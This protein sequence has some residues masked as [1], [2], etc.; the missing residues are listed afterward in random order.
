[1]EKEDGSVAPEE[2][3][4]PEQPVKEVKPEEEKKEEKKEEEKK[5]EKEEEKEEEEEEEEKEEEKEKIE[6]SDQVVNEVMEPIEAKAK[7]S[8]FY[9][10]PIQPS[11]HCLRWEVNKAVMWV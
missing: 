2:S 7:Q 6:I 5:E 3:A 9:Y 8:S 11:E 4:Q 1:M 10:W